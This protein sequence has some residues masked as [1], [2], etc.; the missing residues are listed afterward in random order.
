[1]VDFLKIF[2]ELSNLNV[3]D[4][5]EKKPTAGG[6]ELSYLSWAYAVAEFTKKYPNYTY[7]I[8]MFDGKPYIYDDN[9]GYMVFT[10]I[11]IGD[12]TKDMW[13][14]V[15]D[16][17]NKAMKKEG[18]SYKTKYGEKFVEPATMFDVNKTI[19]R[20]LVKNMAMFGLGLYIYAGD[21]L[22]ECEQDNKEQ[23]KE[24]NE[25]VNNVKNVFPNATEVKIPT[26]DDIKDIM[27]DNNYESF[28]ANEFYDYYSKKGW[29]SKTGQAIT[30]ENVGEVLKRWELSR[31]E[32]F[33]KLAE[34]G[35]KN[36]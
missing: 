36:V 15:I 12:M 29:K 4:K 2:T 32:E 18:Y 34:K 6:K 25:T 35:V 30:T 7:E 21:D 13:L 17:N 20:C 22:P 23:D 11:T 31:K 1:M 10:S 8:K 19:M 14:P 9:L 3:N 24:Q 33:K 16:N 5:I 27:M 26:L 28:S